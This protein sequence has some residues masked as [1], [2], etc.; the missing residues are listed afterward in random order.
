M[1]KVKDYLGKENLD[2]LRERLEEFFNDESGFVFIYTGK[3]NRLTDAY[4]NVC[5]GCVL[6]G[7][8]AVLADAD[9]IGLLVKKEKGK[10]R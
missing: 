6:K 10:K 1:M 8:K 5:A 4:K 9:R 2:K 3:N 7:V